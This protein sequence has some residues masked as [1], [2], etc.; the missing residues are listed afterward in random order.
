MVFGRRAVISWS[1]LNLIMWAILFTATSLRVKA[2]QNVA[3]NAHAHAERIQR[4]SEEAA[5]T[6]IS[7]MTCQ[8]K[9]DNFRTALNEEEKRL[10][11]QAKDDTR[12][13]G[14]LR[15]VR[16]MKGML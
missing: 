13:A 9:L 7:Q 14:V 1:V 6:Q 10:Q 8:F 5:A 2:Y 4:A 11:P 16:V 15:L 3:M 12:A